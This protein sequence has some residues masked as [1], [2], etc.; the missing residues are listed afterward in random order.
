MTVVKGASFAV[1]LTKILFS[2]KK[3]YR[4]RSVLNSAEKGSHNKASGLPIPLHA[5][6]LLVF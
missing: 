5:F 2:S 6:L 1:S 3:S 4:N